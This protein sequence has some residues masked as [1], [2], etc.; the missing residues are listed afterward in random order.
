MIKFGI[1]QFPGSNS[2]Y[3][4]YYVA[5]D[6]INQEAERAEGEATME[7]IILGKESDWIF[8]LFS[9]ISSWIDGALQNNNQIQK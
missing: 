6:V 8:V 5:S 4:A 1:V 2:D 9:F 3:D 7:Q